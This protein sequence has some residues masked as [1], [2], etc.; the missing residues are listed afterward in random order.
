MDYLDHS[1]YQLLVQNQMVKFFSSRKKKF[2]GRLAMTELN[3][4]ISVPKSAANRPS[5]FH[6]QSDEFY[7]TAT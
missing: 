4:S 5:V 7:S 6:S 3:R 1:F 2:S